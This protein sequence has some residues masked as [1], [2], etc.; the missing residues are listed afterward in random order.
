MGVWGGIGRGI[1]DSS[2]LL[3]EVCRGSTSLM[4]FTLS[5]AKPPDQP[6]HVSFEGGLACI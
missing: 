1:K 5:S 6:G 4:I 2:T 3:L